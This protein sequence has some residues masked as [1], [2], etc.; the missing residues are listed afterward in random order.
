[1][2][3]PQENPSIELAKKIV[4]GEIPSNREIE[5]VIDNTK[6]AIESQPLHGQYGARLTSDLKETLTDVK[7]FIEMKNPNEEIQH[8]VKDAKE[9]AKESAAQAPAVT[10]HGQELLSETQKKLEQMRITG[11]GPLYHSLECLRNAA[12]ALLNSPELR[13]FLFEFIALMQDIVRPFLLFSSKME[14]LTSFSFPF[15]SP[16][17]P[18]GVHCSGENPT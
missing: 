10:Q 6:R 14:S 1:M 3:Q 4:E 15:L 9:I 16:F 17:L 2:S 18:A 5:E 13:R 7:E 8:L 12:K 11:E